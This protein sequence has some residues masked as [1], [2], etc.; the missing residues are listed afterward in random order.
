MSRAVAPG[1]LTTEDEGACVVIGEGWRPD[2]VEVLI[3]FRSKTFCSATYVDRI[4]SPTAF[5]GD[6]Q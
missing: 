5:D 4:K 2:V 1:S 3:L 6:V